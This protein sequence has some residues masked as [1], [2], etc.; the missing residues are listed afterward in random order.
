MTLNSLNNK[1]TLFLTAALLCTA[2][3]RGGRSSSGVVLPQPDPDQVGPTAQIYF[4]A[5]RS[6]TDRN[7][8]TVSGN[9]FDPSGIASLSVNGVATTTHDRYAN[10]TAQVPLVPGENTLAITTSD[11][12]GN[13]T[14]LSS[15]A[16]IEFSGPFLSQVRDIRI[17]V[18]GSEAF[19]VDSKID[20][21]VG[22]DLTSGHRRELSGP[23][24]GTGPAFRNP[25]SISP[26]AAG[27]RALVLDRG[28]LSVF[29]VDL[30]TGDRVERFLNSQLTG[31]SYQF[32]QS[33]A[34]DAASQR[35]FVT[36]APP[37]A[38]ESGIYQIDM[39]S[40]ATA[41]L[42]TAAL[43]G[44]PAFSKPNGSDFAPS[45]GRLFV[46]DET[47]TAL[48]S[49][50]TTDGAR[51][52]VAN[53]FIGEGPVLITPRSPRFDAVAG[54][55]YLVDSGL[56]ALV[57]VDLLTGDRTAISDATHG[58]GPPLEGAIAMELDPALSRALVTLEDAVIAIDLFTGDRVRQSGTQT[59][60]GPDL[61]SITNAYGHLRNG[62]IVV[63]GSDPAN[64]PPG[65]DLSVVSVVNGNRDVIASS[66]S[67]T[68]V[69]VLQQ[70]SF[71]CNRL[72]TSAV[73]LGRVLIS[74][75]PKLAVYTINLSN[76]DRTLHYVFPN[77]PVVPDAADIEFDGT[78]SMAFVSFQDQIWK[79]QLKLGTAEL[80]SGPGAGFGPELLNV[81]RMVLD[82]AIGRLLITDL[83]HGAV[84]QVDLVTGERGFVSGP[85]TG[86]GP[87]GGTIHAIDIDARRRTVVFTDR[88]NRSV[89][90]AP[91]QTGKRR[92]LFA[93]DAADQLFPSDIP[94]DVVLDEDHNVV[95]VIFGGEL[96]A[97]VMVEMTTLDRVLIS[98]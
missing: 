42:S 27:S 8:V 46:V 90:V 71:E 22:I 75:Q 25:K 79:V 87:L 20:A 30:V 38:A 54:V 69:E 60:S 70:Y 9:A 14:F 72:L 93:G 11:M 36:V 29:D 92:L 81:R 98:R 64:L 19:V 50:N 94:A 56:N 73:A 3:G 45:L 80:L 76:S 44:G 6:T 2:C 13:L 97:I 91:I 89:Y 74:G 41:P 95:Y 63:Q 62:T 16:V 66:S 82:L 4:P 85:L 48:F 17:P 78:N 47:L 67:G 58:N 61:Q 24:R 55:V 39:V 7:E 96:N 34:L 26:Y 68:G 1:W 21:L 33:I 23:G 86:S 37:A 15:A 49:V 83:G 88:G 28:T 10:W 40:G 43:G 12:L 51:T 53:A 59:G 65:F 32:A 5:T 84:M 31:A 77:A 57:S 35:L 52:V 18:S